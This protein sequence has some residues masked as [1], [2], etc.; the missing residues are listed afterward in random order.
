VTRGP[1]RVVAECEPVIQTDD[2]RS[3]FLTGLKR[4]VPVIRSGNT[5][6]V[7]DWA[8]GRVYEITKS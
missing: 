5:V 8:A 6:L 4:P 3:P 7:G 2:A 1:A